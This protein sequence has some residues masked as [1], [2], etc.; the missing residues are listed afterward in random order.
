MSGIVD[1]YLMTLAI[2]LPPA[3]L[4][5]ASWFPLAW[6]YLSEFFQLACLMSLYA[7]AMSRAPAQVEHSDS[8]CS[9]TYN[10]SFRIEHGIDNHG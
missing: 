3:P 2:H 7:R 9:T 1:S 5:A 6:K 4:W 8:S 10:Q